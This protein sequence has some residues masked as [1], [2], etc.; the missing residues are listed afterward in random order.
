MDTSVNWHVFWH[1]TCSG[2]VII[3]AISS[4]M[5]GQS[6]DNKLWDLWQLFSA[7]LMPMTTPCVSWHCIA[8]AEFV[9]LACLQCT[10]L[11][12]ETVQKGQAKYLYSQSKEFVSICLTC[13][14][15]HEAVSNQPLFRLALIFLLNTLKAQSWFY[16]PPELSV[17]NSSFCP[18]NVF[19]C[20]L[21]KTAIISLYNI[22][23]LVFITKTVCVYC[24]V[25]TEF[26]KV[27]QVPFRG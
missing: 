7:V 23:W 1:R 4:T 25:R 27:T 21:W 12:F 10:G 5:Y 3:L 20:F 26:L 2:R 11:N 16:V 14:C 24:A 17:R 18:P 9:S 15:H 19:M 8:R 22:N 13:Y 6:Q